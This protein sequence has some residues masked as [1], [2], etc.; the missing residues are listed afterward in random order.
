MIEREYINIA[1]S[2]GN[3]PKLFFEKLL[4]ERSAFNNWNRLR[5]FW[6]DERC[7]PEIDIE[8][9]YGEAK[10]ILFDNMK[11]ETDAVLIPDENIFRIKGEKDPAEEADRY[12]EV[13]M[14]ELPAV[15]TF[16]VFDLLLLGIGD[17]G[18]TAS[19]FPGMLEMMDTDKYCAAVKHPVTG[20][21]RV[22]LTGKVINNSKNIFFLVSGRDKAEIISQIINE[23]GKYEK[24]PAFYIK[25]VDGEKFYYLDKDAAEFLQ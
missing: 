11:S 1:F 9:N 23:I 14:K 4:N 7:V 25:P 17:D 10:R 22:T 6:V 24:Y 16:P 2:G 8:S 20:Q 18:H 12:S 21:Y 19:I 3:T 13:L 15:N 5:F